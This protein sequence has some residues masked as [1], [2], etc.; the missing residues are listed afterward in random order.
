MQ[1]SGAPAVRN[2]NPGIVPPHLAAPMPAANLAASAEPKGL[3]MDNARY[4]IFTPRM[5]EQVRERSTGGA[6][7]QA[8]IGTIKETQAFFES[9]GVTERD[10]N[11][12]DLQVVMANN[13]PNAGY[14]SRE[15]A[16]EAG[17]GRGDKDIIIVGRDPQ[18]G[19]SYAAAKDVIAHEYSHRIIDRM[20][21]LEHGGQ[22]GAMNESLADTFAS[23]M[24]N[25]WTIG[26]DIT[27][28]G[29]RDMMHPERHGDP[30]HASQFVRTRQD[31]G[32]VHINNGIPNKAAAL[33]GETLGRKTMAQI[34][35]DAMRNHMTSESGI[36]DTARATM[37]AATDRFGAQSGQL[38]AVKQAWDAVGVLDLVNG[39][40]PSRGSAPVER[41]EVPQQRTERP[42]Y[43]RWVIIPG[44]DAH[45]PAERNAP[46]AAEAAK[47]S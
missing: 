31:Q 6:A 45:D 21:N 9:L 40:R 43:R 39:R 26:E 11:D 23:A 47:A 12:A 27:P 28:G 35:V 17:I 44:V 33:I 46:A 7:G 20:L 10:G 3:E 25:D 15:N 14:I 18:T 2:G 4:T 8:A 36:V 22:T 42:T 30:G 19:Q 38:E 16:A 34:Y 29:I 37:A 32:G 1:V 24:D 41:Y 5:R 13:F